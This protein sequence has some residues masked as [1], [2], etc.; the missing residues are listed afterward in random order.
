MKVPQVQGNLSPSMCELIDV[1]LWEES[2]GWEKLCTARYT[3]GFDV[4]GTRDKGDV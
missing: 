3:P 1:A 4:F 2:W